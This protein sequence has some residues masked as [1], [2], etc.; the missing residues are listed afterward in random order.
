MNKIAQS[1]LAAII[2]VGFMGG[3]A[4]AQSADCSGTI[5]NTGADSTN[6]VGCDTSTTVK[7]TCKN[8]IYVK[9]DNTQDSSTGSI[10]NSNNTS[11][12]STTTGNAINENGTQVKIG[13][14]CATAEAAQP[15]TPTVQPSGGKGSVGGGGGAAGGLGAT[16]AP[17]SLA[18]RTEVA[19]LPNTASNPIGAIA[20]TGAASLAGILSLSRIAVGGYRRFALK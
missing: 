2:S 14:S 19:A 1:F 13:A 9:N 7:V 11:T 8:G 16:L 15:V 4:G 5:S 18:P 12:G 10:N 6:I 3:I 17:A 20:L